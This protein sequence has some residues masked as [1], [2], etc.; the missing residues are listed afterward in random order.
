L[1]PTRT[2]KFVPLLILSVILF[3]GLLAGDLRNS[4][5]PIPR[6]NIQPDQPQFSP[7]FNGITYSSDFSPRGVDEYL[8]GE[9]DTAIIRN[10]GTDALHLAGPTGWIGQSFSTTVSNLLENRSFLRN[11]DFSSGTSSPDYW[12]NSTNHASELRPYYDVTKRWVYVWAHASNNY[13]AGDKA[14]WTQTT[15]VNRSNVQGAQLQFDIWKNGTNE[16][17]LTV[18]VYVNTKT[19][20]TTTHDLLQPSAQTI[21]VNLIPSQLPSLPGN[22]VVTLELSN[23]IGNRVRT[24]DKNVFFDNV[25]LYINCQPSPASVQL[26]LGGNTVNGSTYGSGSVTFDPGTL[27][28]DA[29]FTSN[30]T[31]SLVSSST[32]KVYKSSPSATAKFSMSRTTT[33]VDWAVNKSSVLDQANQIVGSIKY[34]KYSF[35]VSIPYSWNLIKIRLPNGWEQG[36]NS[37]GVKTFNNNSYTWI[38]S[39]N[40]T[41]VDS[42]RPDAYTIVANSNNC[43]PYANN[44]ATFAMVAGSWIQRDFFGVGDQIMINATVQLISSQGSA[45]VVFYSASDFS[46]WRDMSIFSSRPDNVG[47]ASF[48]FRWA[49]ENV[50]RNSDL[51]VLAR[52][53]NGSDV[54]L[55]WRTISFDL[56]PPQ[57]V[58]S[59]ASTGQYINGITRVNI[60]CTDDYLIENVSLLID[61]IA[62][63]NWT[64][65]NSKILS[66]NYDLNTSGYSDG[67]IGIEL[68]AWDHP[69]HV[70]QT[71]SLNIFIDNTPPSAPALSSPNDGDSISVASPTLYW[72]ASSD[73]SGSGVDHYVLQLDTSPSFNSPNLRTVTLNSTSYA[74]PDSQP[75]ANG[76]WYWHVSAEDRVGNVGGYSS[77]R[78]LQIIVKSAPPSEGLPLPILVGLLGGIPAIAILSSVVLLRRRKAQAETGE[79]NRKSLMAAYIFSGDGRA[80]FSYAFKETKMEPQLLSGFLTA[81]SEMMKEVVGGEKRPLR[82]IERSDAKILIEFGT[83]VTGALVTKEASREYRRRLRAFIARFE[84]DYANNISKWDGDQAVFQ[85]APDIIEEVF[86]PS[87]NITTYPTIAGLEDLLVSEKLG[88][89][90]ISVSGKAGSGNAEFCLRYVASLLRRGKPVIAVAASVSPYE[91]R[92]QLK[93][94]GVNLEKSEEQDILIIYDAYSGISGVQSEEKYKYGSPGEL[95]NI[96]LALSR[97]LGKLKNVTILFDS[98]STMIDYSDLELAVDFIRAAKVKLQQGGHTALF[99]IDSNAHDENTLNYILHVMDGEIETVAEAKK[100]GELERLV[101]F[102]RLKG[103]KV[104]PGYHEFR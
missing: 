34:T 69:G 70:N 23:P 21:N 100:K 16:D 30:S 60:Y 13:N 36:L 1:A 101:S 49:D 24:D 87:A 15:Y 3:T 64:F 66:I 25:R 79:Y 32:I 104:K 86:A 14:D 92:E 19:I 54:G 59:L 91:I 77:G 6:A 88:G 55:N 98:L 51:L 45:Y 94:N 82:T 43:I 17:R 83:T 47:V 75:L 68:R 27:P 93:V 103:F 73:G 57:P 4:G 41:A 97:N 22:L 99:I 11:S 40:V 63:R 65:V 12:T 31:I 61:G 71:A 48:N 90:A 102:K 80:M 53:N 18:S 9:N 8:F 35:N 10:I 74:V 56:S 85:A 39:V 29:Y 37:G 33:L 7:S 96:N 44:I 89:V 5:S 38:V 50:S 20:W 95:N 76:T 84:D 67:P 26:K 81:I 2:V 28:Y 52:W 62:T 78:S 72:T 46:V 58:V 42:Y